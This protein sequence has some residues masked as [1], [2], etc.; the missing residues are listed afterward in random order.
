LRRRPEYQT[1]QENPFGAN[2]VANRDHQP[3]QITYTPQHNCQHH[4]ARQLTHENRQRTYA[5][6]TQTRNKFTD[7]RNQQKYCG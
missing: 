2:V 4:R 6:E 7:N 1:S 3:H 5:V